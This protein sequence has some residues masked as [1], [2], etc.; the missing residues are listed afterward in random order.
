M[1]HRRQAFD[2]NM[3]RDYVLNS[4][5]MDNPELLAYIRVMYLKRPSRTDYLN[6]TRTKE[7]DFVLRMLNN[8]KSGLYF[9]Y[10]STVSI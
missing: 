8:K 10:I 4:V 1:L 6:A 3:T 5:P 9:E 2:A 7:E